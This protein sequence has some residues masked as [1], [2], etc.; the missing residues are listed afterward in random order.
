VHAQYGS[1]QPNNGLIREE[2][3]ASGSPEKRNKLSETQSR[4]HRKHSSTTLKTV[5]IRVNIFN[6]TDI[7][8]TNHQ[9]RCEFF[10]EAS[11][12]DFRLKG[13]KSPS[14]VDWTK[15]WHPDLQFVNQIDKTDNEPEIWYAIFDDFPDKPTEPAVVCQRLRLHGTFLEH[16]ELDDFPL[17]TQPLHIVIRSAHTSDRVRLVP[18]RNP[19]YHSIVQNTY[20]VLSDEYQLSRH[21]ILETSETAPELS[22]SGLTYGELAVS[23]TVRRH[24][25]YYVWNVMVPTFLITVM[26]FTSFVIPWDD[27]ADRLQVNLTLCLT[28]IA[29]KIFVADKLPTVNYLT[30]LDKYILFSFVILACIVACNALVASCFLQLLPEHEMPLWDARC[31]YLMLAFFATGN[32]VVVVHTLRLQCLPFH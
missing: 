6:I 21:V 19:K 10:L 3:H 17:D 13:P 20:F 30:M 4:H 29:F 5:R 26:A 22:C 1:I 12:T 14:D 32:V 31:M 15:E 18:N 28:T 7:D 8:T 24:I 11:W 25:G 27:T 16:L 9:F 2:S 23:C